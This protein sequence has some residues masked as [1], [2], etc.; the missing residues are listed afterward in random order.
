M[1]HTSAGQDL[2]LLSDS[3]S[4]ATYTRSAESPQTI[5][6]ATEQIIT[7]CGYG[8][9]AFID[10]RELWA[11]RLHPDDKEATLRVFAALDRDE[12]YTCEYRWRTAS[13]NYKWFRDTGRLVQGAQN[14]PDHIVCCWQLIGV[15]ANPYLY[16]QDVEDATKRIHRQ[17]I[18]VREPDDLKTIL[19]FDLIRELSLL[20]ISIN[21][22]SIELPTSDPAYFMDAHLA[23]KTQ[24]VDV[25]HTPIARYPWVGQ[26]WESGEA[27][28]IRG[29]QLAAADIP[30][31]FTCLVELPLPNGGSIGLGSSVSNNF[32]PDVIDVIQRFTNLFAIDVC[33]SVVERTHRQQRALITERVHRTILEMQ[34]AEDFK[35]VAETISHALADLGLDIAGLS[36][37][38]IDENASTLK[39]YS[40]IAGGF[41]KCVDIQSGL[42]NYRNL[43][44]HWR[45]G[46]VWERSPNAEALAFYRNN[47]D[48]TQPPAV[49]IDTP[50]TQGTMGIGVKDSQVG[51]NDSLIELMNEI[52][53]LL[54]LGC[55][56]LVDFAARREAN[57]A[58]TQQK[59][60]AEQ[61]N[62]AKSEFLANMSHEIRTPMNAVIGMTELAISNALDTT[63]REYLDIAKQSAESLLDILNDILDLSKIE[64]GRL[65]LDPVAFPLR[66]TLENVTRIIDTTAQQ[67]GLSLTF[68]IDPNLPEH[69]VGDPVRLR[70]VLINLLNNAVKFTERG[71]IIVHITSMSADENLQ[72]LHVSVRDSGIGISP[73]K[74]RAIFEPFTQADISTTRRFGGTGLGLT[75]S[76]QIVEMMGGTLQVESVEGEGSTFSFTAL[77]G[78]E[79][80]NATS[81]T[82]ATSHALGG[83]II[84]PSK[85]LRILIVD[86]NNFNQK[87]AKGLLEKRGHTTEVADDGLVALDRLHAE[88]FDLVLM[89]L[90]MPNM[91]G[92]E[93][94]QHIRQK[95]DSTGNHLA[96]IGLTAHAMKGDRDRCLSAG[97][98]GYLSKPIRSAELFAQVATVFGSV[99]T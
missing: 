30:N 6:V 5:T 96:I 14:A 65:E 8:P 84:D 38:L 89:D 41:K 45:H 3:L 80:G 94:T 44:L 52:C 25:E 2:A 28:I 59:E 43:L 17:L 42:K 63:Q 35:I 86:D 87:V 58:L 4:L 78:I 33:Q 29:E 40:V 88:N 82:E 54:S 74:Q 22:V 70:Q 68:D 55:R 20:G 97:M 23:F 48:S 95:E 50:F 26:V 64:A 98:D 67:K 39:S 57:E 32:D 49:I 56:R 1:N 47:S 85:P 81:P 9:D 60:E 10:D 27:V 75:I 11:Q 93:A 83:N 91:D 31:N 53:T 92:I 36:L 73:E 21:S 72:Q 71:A 79:A 13:E 46:E 66:Q 69:L 15:A 19:D 77:F 12:S 62:R 7:L 37:N 34:Q 99:S 76:S 61:A 51:R 24:L 16:N 18:A 90:Q